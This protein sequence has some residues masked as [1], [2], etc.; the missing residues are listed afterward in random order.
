ML[1]IT[2]SYFGL[3]LLPGFAFALILGI[4]QQRFLI[5]YSLNVSFFTTACLVTET[6]PSLAD[7]L[8]TAYLVTLSIVLLV[9][10]LIS[11]LRENHSPNIR[12][13]LQANFS[14]T[15]PTL[16]QGIGYPSLLIG[17]F[18][19]YIFTVNP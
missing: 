17:L 13:F 2:L 5:S 12:G 11:L 6:L 14:V 1:L 16:A 8:T 19:G 3:F 4:Q 18:L 9:A 15:R 7:R 10:K